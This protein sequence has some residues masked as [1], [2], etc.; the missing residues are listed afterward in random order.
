MPE[1]GT[2]LLFPQNATQTL[3]WPRGLG[4]AKMRIST[5]IDVVLCLF[6]FASSFNP[7]PWG[8][9]VLLSK[10]HL[11]CHCLTFLFKLRFKEALRALFFYC[12]GRTLT[13]CVLFVCVLGS[14]HEGKNSI[15]GRRT[16]DNFSTAKRDRALVHNVKKGII[17]NVPFT[18]KL[19]RLTAP[20][21][22]FERTKTCT[23]PPFV[24]TGR[25]ELC[26]F[27]N[28]SVQVF[29]WPDRVK[30]FTGTVPLV[31]TRVN[32][33]E[34]EFARLCWRVALVKNSSVRKFVGTLV[35]GVFKSR[36]I[37]CCYSKSKWWHGI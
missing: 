19:P 25:A 36:G 13:Q 3:G 31:R 8:W 4:E 5:L 20:D 28:G 11:Y 32:R 37:T 23:D 9:P 17:C 29:F 7:I 14:N 12:L 33:T 24:Y 27:L 6:D 1:R 18:V 35:N 2:C 26:N 34:T 10:R 16:K 30:I 15:V 22:F 21:T